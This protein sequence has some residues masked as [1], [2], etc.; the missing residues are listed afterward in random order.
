MAR[1]ILLACLTLASVVVLAADAA[2]CGFDFKPGRRYLVFASKRTLDGRWS[3]SLCSATREFDGS[4]DDARFLASLARP[5][6]GGR[7]FGAV[8]AL[9]ADR[10]RPELQD[11]RPGGLRDSRRSAG[12]VRHRDQPEG[13]AL[14]SEP[15]RP[16]ALSVE[17]Y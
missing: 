3:V 17:R 7:I 16:D 12:P 4:G 14:E 11:G 8:R 10:Y 9:D 6:A 15:L 2:A 5:P 1:P 13:S